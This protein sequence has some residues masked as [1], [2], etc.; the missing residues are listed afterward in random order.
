MFMLSPTAM[1]STDAAA[2]LSHLEAVQGAL[3]AASE[4]SPTWMAYR[5]QLVKAASK[6]NLV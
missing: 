2:L 6:R 3:Q 4:P 1:L 5:D